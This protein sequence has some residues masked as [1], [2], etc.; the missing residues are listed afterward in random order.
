MPELIEVKV[1]NGVQIKVYSAGYAYG[2]FDN[3]DEGDADETR[4]TASEHVAKFRQ[5]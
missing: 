3:T 4:I 1:E 2:Y 5:G